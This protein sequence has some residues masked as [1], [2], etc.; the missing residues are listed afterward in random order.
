MTSKLQ[1]AIEEGDLIA[2]VVALESGADIEESDVHGYPGLP[3]RLACFNGHRDIIIE[4]LDRG[5]DIHALN[6]Q[7]PGAPIRMAIR[8]GHLEV[9]E[10]L[11]ER[12][13]EVPA[14]V[15]LQAVAKQ[16]PKAKPATHPHHHHTAKHAA[17]GK[18]RT[19]SQEKHSATP[20]GAAQE[21]APAAK[22]DP[23][24]GWDKLIVF[25]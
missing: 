7:G 2:V 20:D 14:N 13:A 11:V 3:L 17:H 15:D 5:A 9:I 6:H 19:H 8:G 10:L 1:Q 16:V 22:D 21:S 18:H 23:E 12:G 4:L 24:S 25:D